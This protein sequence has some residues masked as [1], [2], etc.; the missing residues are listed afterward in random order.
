[1]SAA[2]HATGQSE[3]RVAIMSST[4]RAKHGSKINLEVLYI[5]SHTHTLVVSAEISR[6]DRSIGTVWA[7]AVSHITFA[8]TI[9]AS[10]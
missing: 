1:M 7:G 2:K 8:G 4:N 5:G 3:K 6:V 10:Y 9:G